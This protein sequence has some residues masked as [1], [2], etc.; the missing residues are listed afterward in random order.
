M[1]HAVFIDDD[2]SS[3]VLFEEVCRL[4][5]I[6]YTG[7][8]KPEQVVR[9][10]S[11][12]SHVDIILL[13][14]QMPKYSGYDI[15]KQLRSQPELQSLPIVACTVYSDEM[16]RARD[17]GFSSFIVKPL[18]INRF[19]DQLASILQGQGLWETHSD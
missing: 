13:D 9:Q 10:L 15:L 14:L 4:Y 19:P 18:N 7:I 8:Q 1:V 12:L 16:E 2:Q 3:L 5:K 11:S 6:Q 17:A